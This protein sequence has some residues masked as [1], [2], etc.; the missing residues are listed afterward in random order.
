MN[1]DMDEMRKDS[2]KW[3]LYMAILAAVGFV[4]GVL[5]KFAFGIVGENITLNVRQKLYK[6][7]LSKSVGWFDQKENSAGTL[8]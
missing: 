4:T 5:Q 2:N 8:A 6:S 3:C 7:I 1:P